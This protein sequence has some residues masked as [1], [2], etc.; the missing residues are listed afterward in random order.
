MTR[1]TT[2][3]AWFAT[4][5]GR[6]PNGGVTVRPVG[7]GGVVWGWSQGSATL[8]PWLSPFAALR[9][10][11]DPPLQWGV[12]SGQ[13]PVPVACASRHSPLLNGFGVAMSSSPLGMPSERR[14]GRR[15][16]VPYWGSV[17]KLPSFA[18]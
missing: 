18:V 10:G 17:K 3:N 4:P 14:R 7:A 6:Q 9:R 1:N 11:G 13:I 12:S 15:H 5:S 16:P 8:H 2:R